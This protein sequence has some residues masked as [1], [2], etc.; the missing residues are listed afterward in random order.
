M[1][2]PFSD[3]Y[4]EAFSLTQYRYKDADNRGAR[5]CGKWDNYLRCAAQARLGSCEASRQWRNS[6]LADRF[7]GLSCFNLNLL[8]P[9]FDQLFFFKF[10][11]KV[12]WL[13]F[14]PKNLFARQYL[15]QFFIL[16][17]KLLIKHSCPGKYFED[18]K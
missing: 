3:H 13:Y 15:A 10:T 5:I 6:C 1:Q 4:S 11:Y 16:S 9:K 8:A 17:E 14:A 18:Q 12:L 7:A 2:W